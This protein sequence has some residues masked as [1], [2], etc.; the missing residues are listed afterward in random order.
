M[1]PNV[2]FNYGRGGRIGV[3][4]LAGAA[5]VLAIVVTGAVMASPPAD[6]CGN[7]GAAAP[8]ATN[9]SSLQPPS[10]PDALPSGRVC[11]MK[12]G[13]EPVAVR[14]LLDGRPLV[15]NFWASWCGP[16]V[17]ELPALQR[18]HSDHGDRYRVV[19]VATQDALA[20]ARRFANEAGVTYDLHADPRGDYF[21]EAGGWGWPTTLFV[22]ADGT[23]RYHHSGPLDNDDLDRL[24]S[25]HLENDRQN[26]D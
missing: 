25:E 1:I 13:E 19:G 20:S 17:Q 4:W 18:F 12:N 24:V 7:A 21:A 15:L 10:G 16:C 26:P 3:A 14:D 5:V 9:R 2:Q 23:V 11:A 8:V 22:A 6:S